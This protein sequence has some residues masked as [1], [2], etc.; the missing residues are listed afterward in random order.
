MSESI[1][2][3]SRE[4]QVAE[5]IANRASQAASQSMQALWLKYKEELTTTTKKVQ[6]EI[7]SDVQKQVNSYLEVAGKVQSLALT[8]NCIMDAFHAYL[9]TKGVL[10]EDFEPFL[11][12]KLKEFEQNLI[13]RLNKIEQEKSST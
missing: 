4:A 9:K 6:E 12:E 10:G 2:L 8:I 7:V 13:N 5:L 1:E 11:S 3:T